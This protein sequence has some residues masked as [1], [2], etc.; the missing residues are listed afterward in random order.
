MIVKLKDTAPIAG[1]DFDVPKV[2]E[3]YIVYG[4]RTPLLASTND[5]AENLTG[6]EFLIETGEGV[7]N[8][9]PFE[10]Q[11]FEIV[12]NSIPDNWIITSEELATGKR[13]LLG[14]PGLTLVL[15]SSTY[16]DKVASDAFKAAKQEYQGI[17]RL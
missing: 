10:A 16:G 1:T 13:L 3:K 17:V 15:D 6:V 5:S 4:I 8:L 9:F 7:T 11:H 12:E 14:Y 2:G